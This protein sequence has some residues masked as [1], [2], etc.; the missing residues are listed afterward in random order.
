MPPRKAETF[1][2]MI[3]RMDQLQSKEREA[4]KIESYIKNEKQVNRKVEMNQTLNELK[5]DIRSL[6]DDYK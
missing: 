5:N 1:E 3:L 4:G 2:T 6:K